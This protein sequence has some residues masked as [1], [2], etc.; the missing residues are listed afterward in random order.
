MLLKAFIP[1]LPIFSCNFGAF[2]LL[3]LFNF[4]EALAV[5][6]IFLVCSSNYSYVLL[7]ILILFYFSRGKVVRESASCIQS[8]KFGG[9]EKWPRKWIG[10]KKETTERWNHGSLLKNLVISAKIQIKWFFSHPYYCF[11][12]PL[13]KKTLI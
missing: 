9:A 5:S 11:K 6:S 3:I 1:I 2:I 4:N 10:T 13:I 8:Y 7:I 12:I